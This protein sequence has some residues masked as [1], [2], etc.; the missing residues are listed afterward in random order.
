MKQTFVVILFLFKFNMVKH[1][2]GYLIFFENMPY[3]LP[4]AQ[5]KATAYSTFRYSNFNVDTMLN[6]ST[7]MSGIAQSRAFTL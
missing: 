7:H 3:F 4:T 6:F 2:S 1:F 5:N